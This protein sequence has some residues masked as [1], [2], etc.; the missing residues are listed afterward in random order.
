MVKALTAAIAKPTS[1]PNS[2]VPCKTNEHFKYTIAS[3]G[4]GV[5]VQGT[6]ATNLHKPNDTELLSGSWLFVL[7][8]LETDVSQRSEQSKTLHRLGR[9]C[10]EEFAKK[11]GQTKRPV[12]SQPFKFHPLRKKNKIYILMTEV[13]SVHYA[14]PSDLVP[15]AEEFRAS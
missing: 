4:N 7:C 8:K 3:Y 15:A 10:S 11:C 1:P 14:S 2:L 12:K 9:Y 6:L 5:P 13:A